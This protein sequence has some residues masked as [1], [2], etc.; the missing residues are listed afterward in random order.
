MWS[1]KNLLLPFKKIN[2]FCFFFFFLILKIV[3][4]CKGIQNLLLKEENTMAAVKGPQAPQ[5]NL[6]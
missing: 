1:I 3:K 5:F 6:F 2:C 4:N